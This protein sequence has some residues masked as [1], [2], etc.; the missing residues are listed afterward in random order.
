M[1]PTKLSIFTFI[2]TSIIAAQPILQPI[3]IASQPPTIS[4]TPATVKF[5]NQVFRLIQKDI[6]K[7]FGV[8]PKTLRLSGTRRSTWDG[9]MGVAQPNQ[10]CTQIAIFGWKVIVS[11]QNRFWVYHTDL[12]GSKIAYNAT[13]SLPRNTQIPT[14]S[15]INP[16][17]IIPNSGSSVI[18]QSAQITGMTPEYYAVELT[19]DG[20]LTRRAIGRN[21]G[22]PQKIKQ[23]SKLQVQQFVNL[24]QNN[25]FSH[26][27]GLSYL[28][29]SAIA[30]D[31]T[32][33]QLS[34]GG[35]TVE[36][37]SINTQQLPASLSR[38]IQAWQKI[39]KS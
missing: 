20:V 34:Y 12:N 37:T 32:S 35:A 6:Q 3:A 23:L 30:A 22:K 25:S 7:R 2:V 15:F 10:A 17:K 19:A 1:I 4:Q 28:N 13:A 38:V 36:Y 29:M 21:P 24:L 27:D 33:F 9:C 14:P 26:L 39:S 18:F 31:A 16:K 11:G 5:P 8:S